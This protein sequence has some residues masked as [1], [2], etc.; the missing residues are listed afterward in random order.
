MPPTPPPTPGSTVLVEDL[1]YYY[2]DSDNWDEIRQYEGKPAKVVEV[3]HNLIY[4]RFA[5]EP[6][7]AP[8]LAV[9]HGSYVSASP[10]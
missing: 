2:A 6:A 3:G 10:T 8:P 9:P 5:E 7:G 1:S 4:V